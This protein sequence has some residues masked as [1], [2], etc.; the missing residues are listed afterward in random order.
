MGRAS[1]RPRPVGSPTPA[2]QGRR[3]TPIAPRAPSALLRAWSAHARPGT[4]ARPTCSRTF[5]AR[6]GPTALPIPRQRLCVQG[7]ISAVTQ[8]RLR[9]APLGAF[10]PQAPLPPSSAPKEVF[11]QRGRMP[12][13]P[14]L[15]A[16]TVRR[17]LSGS[18]VRPGVFA[19]RGRS[20]NCR[21]R[22]EPIVKPPKYLWYAL[23]EAFVRLV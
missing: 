8:P 13:R 15:L 22:R 2:R 5:R 3:R 14:V 6:Q 7:A 23:Q 18:C 1:R 19:G 9:R 21:A 12:L 4:I 20:R 17:L 10:A 11:A 16:P